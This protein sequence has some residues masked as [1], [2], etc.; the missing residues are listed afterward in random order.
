[1]ADKYVQLHDASGNNLYPVVTDFPI[2]VANG[3]TGATSVASA[4]NAL[5][6]GNTS[7][8]VPVANGGTG[9]TTADDAR[10]NLGF[11][12]YLVVET[13]DLSSQTANIGANATVWKTVTIP[14]KSG[15]TALGVIGYYLGGTIG[16]ICN[17]YNLR[18]T[19]NTSIVTAWANTSSNSGTVSLRTADV[20]YVK[21]S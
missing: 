2:P 12:D 3:G 9:A 21:T 18:L 16:Y 17:V 20:L 10:S 5:G 6:L 11:D 1:M 13:Y 19:N 8:A 15:Y 7:G 14:E 4:R